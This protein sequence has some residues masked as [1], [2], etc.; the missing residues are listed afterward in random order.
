M[1]MH[2]A[3]IRWFLEGTLWE[4]AESWFL[5]G[6]S[7][8]IEDRTD[9]YL[10]LPDCDSTGVK[11]R[12]QHQD[13]EKFKFEIKSQVGAARPLGL[14]NGINGRTDGWVRW[15]LETEKLD[16]LKALEAAI[17]GTGTWVE[18]RKTRLLRK[19]SADGALI[20][21][22]PQEKPDAGCNVELTLLEVEGENKGFS[23][24]FEA[25]GSPAQAS[26]ILDETLRVFFRLYPK[27]DALN[28]TGRNSLSYPAWLA[29]LSCGEEEA[30][31]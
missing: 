1:T 31:R 11:L 20:E 9:D 10:L 17:L 23:L 22:A 27:P 16:N 29:T 18:V 19:F 14:G 26:Q 7:L 24:A 3:E 15:S 8:K 5:A 4:G 28:L 6:Q 21:V 12:G 13:M 25:F 30:A 2:S